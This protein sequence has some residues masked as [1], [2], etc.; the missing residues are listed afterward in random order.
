[1]LNFIF[2]LIFIAVIAF[3]VLIFVGKS[4]PPAP[5]TYTPPAWMNEESDISGRRPRISAEVSEN[6]YSSVQEYCQQ[7]SITISTL[8]RNAVESYMRSTSAS[9][10][11]NIPS[12]DPS[13]R[14]ITSV[15]R[16]D[17]SWKC[18]RCGKINASYIGTCSCGVD[19]DAAP[20]IKASTS[21]K[22]SYIREDGSWKCP[23]CGKVN[24]KYV[25]TCSCGKSEE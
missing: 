19:K 1:M 6:F 3:I 22:P 23:R 8:I 10:S 18:P 2:V 20:T 12:P 24:A 25:G 13:P 4:K 21:R 16:P 5:S 17:G 15:T 11:V 7:N 9:D 14:K